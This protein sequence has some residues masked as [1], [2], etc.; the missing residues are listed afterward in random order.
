MH[1]PLAMHARVN[2]SAEDWTPEGEMASRSMHVT[3][4]HSDVN[5]SM[6]MELEGEGEQTLV[7]DELGMGRRRGNSGFVIG[8]HRKGESSSSVGRGAGMPSVLARGHTPKAASQSSAAGESW[9]P[10]QHQDDE[11]N[12]DRDRTLLGEDVTTSRKPSEAD[13]YDEDTSLGHGD[14]DIEEQDLGVSLDKHLQANSTRRRGTH[15]NEHRKGEVPPMQAARRA[16]HLKLDIHPPSPPPWELV[17]PP[18]DNNATAVGGG[19]DYYSPTGSKFRTLQ[20]SGYALHALPSIC[21][22]MRL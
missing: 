5:K 14:G 11:P 22:L 20:S 19:G 7:E 6:A 16:S 2:S 12:H 8:G 15:A 10:L 17:D 13:R 3:N 21:C 1:H 9:D 4:L 18:L